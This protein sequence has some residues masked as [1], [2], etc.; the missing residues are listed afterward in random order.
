M[1]K[2][3]D[4][5]L[6]Q[7]EAE[8]RKCGDIIWSAHR[9]DYRSCSCGGIAVDGGRDY[10]RRGGDLDSIIERSMYIDSE[11]LQGAQDALNDAAKSG[12]NTLGGVLAVIRSLRDNGLLDM[13]KFTGELL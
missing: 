10:I 1:T 4:R 12:R 6:I 7:N 8:C 3:P 13:D 9:H 2:K 5:I 11:A